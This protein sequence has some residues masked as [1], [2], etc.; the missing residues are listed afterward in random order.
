M[1]L[2]LLEGCPFA[3]RASIALG[4]KSVGFEPVF[5]T[6]GARPAELDTIGPYAKS[7]TI[8]DGEDRVWDSQIVV[9]YLDDR[10]PSPRLLPADPHGRAEARMLSTRIDRE[11]GAKQGVLVRELVLEPV[12]RRDPANVEAAKRDIAA[13]LP[14]WNDRLAARDYLLGDGL[15]FADITLYTLLAAIERTAGLRVPNELTHLRAWFDRIAA[16][17]SA[18]LLVPG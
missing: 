13:M 4:E 11:I 18:R 15:G 10:Y 1:K 17:P 9:E 14:A 7:P 5:F 2:Y 3:H 12:E 6:A 8:V 16:R